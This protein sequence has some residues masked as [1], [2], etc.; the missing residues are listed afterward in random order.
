MT[1]DHT[2][3]EAGGGT[4]RTGG[5]GGGAAG[6][7]VRAAG[8]GYVTQPDTGRRPTF[9]PARSSRPGGPSRLPTISPA[10]PTL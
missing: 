1:T 5:A 2:P 10:R 7:G 4:G 8:T 6:G 9:Y 3:A